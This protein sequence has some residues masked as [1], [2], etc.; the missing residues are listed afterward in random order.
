MIF[1]N[2]NETILE[3][4][5]NRNY[6]DPQDLQRSSPRGQ[7]GDLSASADE[8]DAADVTQSNSDSAQAM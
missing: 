5:W 3:T 1:N 8:E 7:D 6:F 2:Y 4:A